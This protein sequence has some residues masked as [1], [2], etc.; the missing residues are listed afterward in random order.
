M[1]FTRFA[2]WVL[3]VAAIAVLGFAPAALADG[4]KMNLTNVG[5]NVLAGNY[6][7]PYTATVNGVTTLVVCDDFA[8]DSFAG[9]TWTATTNTLASLTGTKWGNQKNATQGYD[10][11]AWLFTQMM[12]SNNPQTVADLQYAIWA[13]FDPAALNGLSGKDLKNVLG[14]L[15]QAQ[16]QNYYTGEFSNIVLYTP[17]KGTQSNC[18]AWGGCSGPPQEFLAYRATTPEPASLLLLGTGFVVCG[19]MMRRT[20]RA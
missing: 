9:E 18:N 3:G 20:V 4:S 12:G 17:N 8:D 11:M 10:E 5:N 13:V 6:V 14:W 15:A 7:G 19:L 1:T 2:K 16:A